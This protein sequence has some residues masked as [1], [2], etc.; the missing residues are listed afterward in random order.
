[1]V[2]INIST[3]DYIVQQT[4]VKPW[5]NGDKVLLNPCPI[6][7]HRDHFFIYPKTN[8]YYSFSGCCRGG[9]LIDWLVEY[10]KL[11][12]AEAMERIHGDAK[13][14]NRTK[15]QENRKLA[16]LLTEKVEGFFNTCIRQFKLF[17]ELEAYMKEIEVDYVDPVYRYIRQAVRFYDR[18][19]SEFIGGD[20][21]KRV[22]LMRNHKNEY[23]FK[24]K[25]GDSIE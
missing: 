21:S 8:S 6:C 23:F 17:S 18:K 13:P 22:Q 4:G 3:L 12:L 14:P 9:S 11:S 2:H 24:L 15:Q 10:E 20:F 19:T 1:M 25:V 16:R 5:K 7:G